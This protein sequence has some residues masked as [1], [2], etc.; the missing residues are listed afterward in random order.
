MSG[1]TARHGCRAGSLAGPEMQGVI[2][3]PRMILQRR[4]VAAK[5]QDWSTAMLDVAIV[6]VGMF[7]GLQVVRQREMRESN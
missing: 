3:V 7:I 5:A 4:A 2:S 1:G 6:V